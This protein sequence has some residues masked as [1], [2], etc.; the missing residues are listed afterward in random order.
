MRRETKLFVLLLSDKLNKC[1]KAHVEKKGTEA[2]P[3]KDA[4]SNRDS[5]GDKVGSN[6]GSLKVVIKARY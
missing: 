4:P 2:V 6:D 1:I 3:L 5:R